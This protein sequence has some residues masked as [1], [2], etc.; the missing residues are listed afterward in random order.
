M[1]ANK[2]AM[3]RYALLDYLLQDRRK[4]WSIQ[5]MTDYLSEHLPEYGSE[6]VSR[7]MVE[8]DLQYLEYNSPFNV[9]F[10]R[11][12]VDAPT[13]SGDGVYKKPCLRYA[14]PTFSIFHKALSDDE[15]S[16]LASVLSTLGSFKGQPNFEWLEALASKLNLEEQQVIISM[17][18]NINE[19][20]TLLTELYRAISSKAVIM[21]HYHTF[22]DT[23]IRSVE[24]SPYLLKEYNNRWYLLASPFDSDRILAFALDRIDSVEYG[25]GKKY[26]APCDDFSERYE[27]IIGITFYENKPVERILFW[28]SAVSRKYL[29]TKPLHGSQRHLSLSEQAKLSDQYSQLPKGDFYTID[30][31]E[32]YELIRELT[33]FGADLIVLSPSH[34]VE[35][36]AEIAYEMNN[37]YKII[38]TNND[39][40]RPS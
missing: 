24:L 23:E 16:L 26:K 3:T 14:D 12:K 38:S 35:K 36:V 33:T 4:N 20:S 39:F 18:K 9:E 25:S 17:S 40:A 1:P 34:I 15:R 30:C 7:R 21:L 22:S 29:D 6:P 5:D 27:D 28:V 10:E 8:K 37:R 13:K 2:N 11:F 32:N 19:N 31:M